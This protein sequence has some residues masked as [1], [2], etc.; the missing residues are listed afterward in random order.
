[1]RKE[2]SEGREGETERR[3]DGEEKKEMRGKGKE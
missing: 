3:R 1:L 2:E